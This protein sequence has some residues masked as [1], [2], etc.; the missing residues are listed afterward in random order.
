MIDSAK[1][2][3][4]LPLNLRSELL[5]TYEE[6]TSNFAAHRWGPSELN[7][8]KFC[9]VVY[10]IINGVLTN[11]LPSKATKPKNMVASCRALEEMTS[12]LNRLGDRSLRIL[13]PRILPF[14]YE[15]RNNRGVGHVGGDV[16]PNLLDATAVC[17]MASWI[18][19]ELVR[20]FHNVATHEAQEI[21]NTLVERRQ[22]L[23]WQIGNTRRVLD[24]ALSN[25]DQVLLLLHQQHTWVT[26][27]NLLLSVE[28]SSAA[29]FRKRILMPLHKKRLIEFDKNKKC[30]HISPAGVAYVEK[31]II[32][33]RAARQ[34]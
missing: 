29:M 1:V 8:G 7:G 10:C 17:N 20:I 34:V 21:V 19:A 22:P 33:P 23:I 11:N 9:E 13:I 25:A 18:L 3:A 31:L 24:T 26:E 15:I 12:D 28:Y 27:D 30:L 32:A 6:I 2:L 16:D 4:G 14:L 5:K